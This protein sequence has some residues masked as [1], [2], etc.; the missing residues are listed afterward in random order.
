MATD[1]AISMTPNLEVSCHSQQHTFLFCLGG[2]AGKVLEDELKSF[3]H[4]I[5][6]QN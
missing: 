5:V 3:V 6:G 1:V 2:A 4:L